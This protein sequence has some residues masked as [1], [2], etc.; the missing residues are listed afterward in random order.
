[1]KI[2][3]IIDLYYPQIGGQQVRFKELCELFVKKGVAVDVYTIDYLG[4]LPSF[5]NIEGVQVHRL[6]SDKNYYKNGLFGRK[7]STFIKYSFKAHRIVKKGNYDA[8]I[9]NQFSFI[10][11]MLGAVKIKNTI[12][13]YV[14]FRKGKIWNVIN[15]FTLPRVDKV[16][17]I[18]SYL[19]KEV[20]E[21]VKGKSKTIT[22]PSLVKSS[23]YKSKPVRKNQVVFIARLEEHKGLPMAIE[24]VQQYNQNQKEPIQLKVAGDGTLYESFKEKFK[25]DNTI[26]FLGRV[27]DKEKQELLSES[28]M[29]IL[30]SKREGLPKTFIEAVVSDLPIITSNHP[31]NYGQYFVEGNQIGEVCET[32]EDYARGIETVLEK[33]DTYQS[34]VSK[35]KKD[36]DV[37]E[38]AKRYQKFIED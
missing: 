17:C 12:I 10:S 18:S 8:V 26:D 30:P 2:A 24:A 28:K 25:G 3:L 11:A 14:E 27:S 7:L 37:E 21:Y 19:E 32:V 31:D 29:L 1:M 9:Y 23:E 5:E 13:D 35:I 34:N 20:K 4:D 22:I 38:G 33:Y 36:F 16:V 15:R 6:F